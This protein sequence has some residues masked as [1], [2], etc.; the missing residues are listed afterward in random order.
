MLSSNAIS[1]NNKKINTEDYIISKD[2]AIDGK[3]VLIR[4]GKKKYF[5]GLFD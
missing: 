3:V 5:L 1:A 2:D 4:K